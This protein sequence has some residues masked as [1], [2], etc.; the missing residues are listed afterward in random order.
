MPLLSVSALSP[1]KCQCLNEGSF[2]RMYAS[3]DH[4]KLAPRTTFLLRKRLVVIQFRSQSKGCAVLGHFCTAAHAC[5]RRTLQVCRF[6]PQWAHTHTA[7]PS[8]TARVLQALLQRTM[9]IPSQDV[10]NRPSLSESPLPTYAYSLWAT[11][12]S[13]M[14][15]APLLRQNTLTSR[16]G[17][18]VLCIASW[19]STNC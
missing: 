19:I 1:W 3:K 16:P 18:Q 15:P 9:T 17:K 8:N 13:D 12:P 2:Q 6:C 14:W 7:C 11:R 5:H 10:S 4:P